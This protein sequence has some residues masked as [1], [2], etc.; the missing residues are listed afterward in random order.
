MSHYPLTS[1]KLLLSE[2]NKMIAHNSFNPTYTMLKGSAVE[3]LNTKF[4]GWVKRVTS[5][6]FVGYIFF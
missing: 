4:S 5:P 1:A 2:P 6:G 3:T